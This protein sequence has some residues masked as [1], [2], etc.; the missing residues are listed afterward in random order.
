MARQLKSHKQRKFYVQIIFVL[1]KNILYS[2][3]NVLLNYYWIK[4]KNFDKNLTLKKKVG[5]SK[6]LKSKTSK[7]Y[8][9]KFYKG[10]KVKTKS[11]LQFR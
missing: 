6:K 7:I 8:N 5:Q 1:K 9:I 3:K 2:V 4:K 11:S 10:Y